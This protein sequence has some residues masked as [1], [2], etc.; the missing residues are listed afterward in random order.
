L[1]LNNCICSFIATLLR[2][3]NE[4]TQFESWSLFRIVVSVKNHFSLFHK[5]QKPK[6]FSINDVNKHI[7]LFF[8]Y[9]NKR[10][11]H[12]AEIK[13]ACFEKNE[14]MKS[15]IYVWT[16]LLLSERF[17][18]TLCWVFVLI[19]NKFQQQSLF[20]YEHNCLHKCW[21]ILNFLCLKLSQM[22]ENSFHWD[23]FSLIVISCTMI[24][25]IISFNVCMKMWHQW[26]QTWH[27]EVMEIFC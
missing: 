24:W 14:P 13:I 27:F 26:H 7:F 5:I 12:Y 8:I 22:S 17:I 15:K 11:Y 9:W 23:F 16:M 2:I 20:Y 6:V 1:L 25:G 19:F 4:F 21:Y 3:Y 18:I 10:N